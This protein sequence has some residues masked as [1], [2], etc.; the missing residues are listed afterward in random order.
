V[1]V[2]RSKEL[3]APVLAGCRCCGK[4]G[5]VRP[6]NQEPQQ[7]GFRKDAGA[8]YAPRH[9]ESFYNALYDPRKSFSKR[10]SGSVG[11]AFALPL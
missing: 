10:E 8:A 5:G 7:Q 2:L 3:N 6:A 1:R 4:I 9:V 11:R